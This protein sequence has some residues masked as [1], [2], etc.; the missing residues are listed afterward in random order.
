MS[1][2]GFQNLAG[3]DRG[4]AADKSQRGT[5]DDA[6]GICDGVV[7]DSREKQEKQEA[8]RNHKARQYTQPDIGIE[9]SPSRSARVGNSVLRLFH[10]ESFLGEW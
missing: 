9:G 3:D 8:C 5:G 2:R 7:L 1:N 10:V 6:T 4:Q